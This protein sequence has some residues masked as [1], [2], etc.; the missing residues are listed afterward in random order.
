MR[1]A[2]GDRKMSALPS[3]PPKAAQEAEMAKIPE[4]DVNSIDPALRSASYA[5]SMSDEA[6][7]E[8]LL[9]DAYLPRDGRLQSG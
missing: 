1:D 9:R 8:E 5:A 3:M 6:F 4:L 7:V 2:P